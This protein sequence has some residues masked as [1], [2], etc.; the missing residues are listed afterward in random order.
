V[1]GEE[2]HTLEARWLADAMTRWQFDKNL[3]PTLNVSNLFD[4]K[5][6]TMMYFY[7]TYSWGEGR[8]AML[9]LDYRF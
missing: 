1:R 8:K 2:K 4:K 3:S 6:Y 9:T 7:N 5:Y